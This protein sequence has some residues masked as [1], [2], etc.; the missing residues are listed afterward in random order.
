MTKKKLVNDVND[1]VSSK[2]KDTK[3]VGV[4]TL[5]SNKEKLT[6]QQALAVHLIQERELRQA[7]LI[8]KDALLREID[9]LY[10]AV[11]SLRRQLYQ[12]RINNIS[13]DNND[14][15]DK[16]K[17]PSGKVNYLIEDGSMYVLKAGDSLV[18]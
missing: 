1:V 14:L 3:E 17:L 6:E 15:R 18:E 16:Y 12:E 2:N 7:T 10:Q 8:E 4:E 13:K 9:S 5:P 11:N